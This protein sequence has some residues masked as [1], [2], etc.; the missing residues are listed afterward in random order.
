M[1]PLLLLL[2]RCVECPEVVDETLHQLAI[3]STHG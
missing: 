2:I 1:N 3:G